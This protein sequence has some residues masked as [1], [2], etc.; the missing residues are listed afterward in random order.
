MKKRL[1]ISSVLMSAVLA[2][3]LGTGTYAWYAASGAGGSISADAYTSGTIS[4]TT[5]E[6]TV[7]GYKLAITVTPGTAILLSDEDDG[8]AYVMV[9][10]DVVEAATQNVV[11]TYTVS[12]DWAAGSDNVT[13]RKELAGDYEFTITAAGSA[14]LLKN[15]SSAL[16]ANVADSHTVVVT[17]SEETGNVTVKSGGTGYYCIRQTSETLETDAAHTGDKLTATWVGEV[18]PE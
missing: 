18:T 8:K 3:A 9:G 1:L 6:G 13:A 5:A 16:K 11:G 7:G 12:I 2:C 17:V 4:T 15:S 14:K 10:E